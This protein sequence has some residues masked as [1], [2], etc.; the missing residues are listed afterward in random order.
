MS[1]RFLSSLL[2]CFVFSICGAAQS[3]VAAAIDSLPKTKHIDQ[4]AISPDGA[5]VAYIVEG[6]LMVTPVAGGEG[7]AIASQPKLPAREVA[8]SADSK[9]V[10]WLAD[11]PGEKPAAELWTASA[12]GS[13]ANK[14]ADL[15]GFAQTIKFAPDGGRSTHQVT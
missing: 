7:H 2:F 1:R 14:L 9:S 10:A 5:Q 6:E 3:R 4:V 11:L 13:G 15:K 12:D 8:W